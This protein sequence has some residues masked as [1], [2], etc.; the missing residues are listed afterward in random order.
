MCIC[1][2][3]LPSNI[4]Q[5]ALGGERNYLHKVFQINT[6]DHVHQAVVS[7]EHIA[8]TAGEGCNGSCGVVPCSLSGKV[9]H[10]QNSPTNTKISLGWRWELPPSRSFLYHRNLTT[11]ARCSRDGEGFEYSRYLGSYNFLPLL[12]G[13]SVNSLVYT[14]NV[15]V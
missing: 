11:T 4:K 8:G 10:C 9:P 12:K 7:S 15:N 1:Q 13:S 14:Q 3:T 5:M 6:F 2:A